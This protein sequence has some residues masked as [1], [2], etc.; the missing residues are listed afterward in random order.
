MDEAIADLIA[1]FSAL[2]EWDERYR[3]IIELGQRLAPLPE[4]LRTDANRVR[5]CVSRLWL[6]SSHESGRMHYRASGDAAIVNGL[7]ALL[8]KV[9]DDR[10]PEEIV[11]TPPDFLRIL[12]L[13]QHLSPLR[14]NGLHFMAQRIRIDALAALEGNAPAARLGE[15][16]G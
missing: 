8:L 1:R 10:K 13:A 16:E 6:A 2:G 5:G 4:E 14:S 12:G 15:P 11:R 7:I 9:Y 3:Y